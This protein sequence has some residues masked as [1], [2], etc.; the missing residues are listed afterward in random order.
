MAVCRFALLISDQL[1][2]CLT[3]GAL[4][5]VLSLEGDDWFGPKRTA[6]LAVLVCIIQWPAHPR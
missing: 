4:N 1:K 2:S 6:E 3:A 5:Y